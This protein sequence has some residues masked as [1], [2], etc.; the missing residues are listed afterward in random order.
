MS[1]LQKNIHAALFGVP[2]L[3]RLELHT[4][5]EKW[6][7]DKNRPT[8]PFQ[9]L[10]ELAFVEGWSLS[11][12]PANPVYTQL[13]QSK[14]WVSAALLGAIYQISAAYRRQSN[15]TRQRSVLEELQAKVARLTASC[16]AAWRASDLKV[17]FREPRPV[18][19]RSYSPEPM[20]AAEQHNDGAWRGK[21]ISRAKLYAQR[22]DL[23]DGGAA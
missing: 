23:R 10:A 14:A 13:S 1:H 7:A 17:P 18:G 11:E 8:I 21:R 6:A 19:V 22:P 2:E 15:D 16:R 20:D 12:L 5:A 4:I 3:E 9:R